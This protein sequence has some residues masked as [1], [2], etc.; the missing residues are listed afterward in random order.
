MQGGKEGVRKEY[1]QLKEKG[2]WYMYQNHLQSTSNKEHIEPG[3]L[4]QNKTWA[5]VF[6]SISQVI[7]IPT[8]V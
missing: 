4:Q 2:L 1:V 7:L 8:E 6:F 5:F 3:L